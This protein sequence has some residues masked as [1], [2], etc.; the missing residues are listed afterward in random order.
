VCNK[1]ELVTSLYYDV[2]QKNIKKVMGVPC[3]PEGSKR[4]RLPDF[5]DIRHMKV[6]RASASRTGPF[7]SQETFLVR[8]FTRG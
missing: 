3:G 7:H 4:F 5:H 1:L 6:V 2:G 8:I